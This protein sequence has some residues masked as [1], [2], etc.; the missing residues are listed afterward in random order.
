MNFTTTTFRVANQNSQFNGMKAL[1][2]RTSGDRVRAYLPPQKMAS[3]KDWL[4]GDWHFS[5]SE[6]V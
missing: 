2:L 4:G 1:D 6:L 5:E 3:G